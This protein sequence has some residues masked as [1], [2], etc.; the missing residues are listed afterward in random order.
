ML[1]HGENE[2]V[3][4][5][6]T[7]SKIRRWILADGFSIREVS[8][9][10]G[11]SRNTIRKYLREDSVEPRY[12]LRRPRHGKRLLDYEVR[13][14]EMVEA[15]LSRPPRERRTMQGLYE[16]IVADGFE[17]SYD[18]V[19]RYIVRLKSK[20][21][22][23]AKGYIPLEFDAGD[24]LQFDWS[25]EIVNLG[26]IEQKV[27]VA[28]FRLCHSRK[29]F[30]AAYM[31]ESQEMV[32][33]AFNRAL[34]YYDGVPR[35]VIIDNPKT[36]VVFIGKGKER[37]FHP[38]FLAL[39]SHY[40]I[41]PVACSPASG[42][43]KGQVES[44]VKT[45]RKQIF[46]PRLSFA[47]LA[48]LNDHLA[49]R[50]DELTNKP[51]PEGRTRTLAEIF[52]QEHSKLRPVGKSFD[53]YAERSVRV[54]G[55][56]LV[57]Y[58]TNSYSVPCTHT[59]QTVSIRAYADR[60]TI[61]DGNTVIAEHQR[62]FDRYKKQFCIWHYLALFQQKP[63]ALRDGAPFKRWQA[64][65]PLAMIWEHYKKQQGGDRD[66]VE[67]L[68]L[69]H[70][71]GHEAVAMACE[72]AA[73]YNTLQLSVIIALLH[74]LIGPVEQKEMAI[75]E[76]SHLQLQLPPQANCHRYDQL[77]SQGEAA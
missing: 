64:P 23:S 43:E 18:T 46:S 26:G 10:T 77:A 65:K 31:R 22:P 37:T 51:H 62:C 54:S 13:L 56:S 3:L 72:L 74:D 2:Q 11:I 59:H 1:L 32:L 70:Q 45:L 8:R 60:I 71:H 49:N 41:E 27:Y 20:I 68:T 61:T 55:T 39:M 48:D 66:F 4:L 63:G 42:W 15:D 67:L 17:G 25:H 47:A 14:R 34:S 30:I 5:M 33:D 9:R 21:G 57:Q 69:Y 7:V 40:A 76:A 50:C 52:K 24:A 75:E 36:M 6:E 53:G 29:P 12:R 35:R 19:R 44:Q 38:R 16:T 28:H 73:E 58:D